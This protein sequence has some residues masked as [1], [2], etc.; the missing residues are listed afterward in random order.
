MRTL[1]NLTL[2]EQGDRELHLAQAMGFL[3]E[4]QPWG[5][6]ISTGFDEAVATLASRLHQTAELGHAALIGGHTGLWVATIEK[7]HED[8]Q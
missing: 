3:L 8:G 7:L 5:V 4:S 6:E 2:H 1:R